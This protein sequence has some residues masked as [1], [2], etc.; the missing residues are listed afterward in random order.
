MYS[1]DRKSSGADCAE[2]QGR[3]RGVKALADHGIAS[4]YPNPRGS[5][6]RGREFARQVKGDMGGEDTHD[7]L[8]GID[9]LVAAGIADP[10]RLGVTERP[11]GTAEIIGASSGIMPGA[12]EQPRS[13]VVQALW[14]STLSN[15]KR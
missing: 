11:Q 9:A 10:K 15:A 12:H 5:S 3:L 8:T 13:L 2:R 1:R 4:I 14:I 7:Y 6:G